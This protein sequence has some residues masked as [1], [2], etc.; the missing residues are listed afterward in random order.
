MKDKK[1]NTAKAKAKVRTIKCDYLARVEGE[2]GFHVKIKENQVVDAKLKIFEPPRFFEAFLRG[3]RFME[4]PDITARICGICPLAYQMSSTHAFEEAFGAEVHPQIRQLRR[5]FYCGEWIES[6]VLH[7]FMLHAPDFLG[8]QDAIRM[9]KDHGDVVKMALDLKKLGNDIVRVLGGREIHPVS[10]CVGG[11]Y[12]VPTNKELEPL[13]D[14]LKWGIEASIKAVRFVATL[15]FPDLDKDYEFVSVREPDAYGMIMGRIVSNKG[16]DIA[17]PEYEEHFEE[18]HVK[19]STSLHSFI[20]ERGPYFVG[21]LARFNLNFE[22]LTPLAKEESKAA[23]FTPVCGNSF[24]GIIARAVEVLYSCEESLRVIE[25][26][27]MPPAPRVEV[28]PIATNAY[29]ASEAPRGLLY[30]RYTV[31]G[32]GIIKDA[33]L[34][35][36]T[37]QNQPT[38]E[39]DLHDFVQ[40][41]INMPKDK[42]TWRCEQVVRN[43][44]P[45]ISCSCHFLKLHIDRS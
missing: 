20:Q 28:Q 8:Y 39:G 34:V 36:P 16:L 26:Y 35:P 3:R 45:C 13:K 9:A 42:M 30:H 12:K 37:S 32:E 1:P 25:Q 17:I 23:N 5:L 24:K 18:Q 31:D 44:D 41:N 33:K 43:Y 2:G 6:H 19:H 10:A 38:I 27:E 21:P 7:V 15:P 11:F 40:K 4:A 29:G 22:Q 14:R